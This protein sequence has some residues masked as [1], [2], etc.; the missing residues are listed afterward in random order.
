MTPGQIFRIGI[1]IHSSPGGGPMATQRASDS[2]GPRTNP[3]Y[4]DGV[5]TATTHDGHDA[6]LWEFTWNG[7]SKG[8]GARH[9]YD[10]CWEQ[11]GRLYDVWVSAPVGSLDTAQRHFTT[12]IGTFSA[13]A[14]ASASASGTGDHH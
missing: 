13:S 12:A 5:V 4:R 11:D 10:L 9:T 14:S 1:R 3:G 6:A 2:A 8:E 7:Y